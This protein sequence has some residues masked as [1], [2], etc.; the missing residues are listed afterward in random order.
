MH[1]KWGHS[2]AKG[3]DIKIMKS[4]T[5]EIVFKSWGPFRIYQ[6]INTANPA[7]FYLKIIDH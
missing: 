6:L 5:I 1:E 4:N 3:F 7:I 2:M